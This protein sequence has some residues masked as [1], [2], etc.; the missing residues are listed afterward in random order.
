[1]VRLQP[2]QLQALDVFR[3]DQSRPAAIRAILKEKLDD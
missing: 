1:M 2:D 3:G